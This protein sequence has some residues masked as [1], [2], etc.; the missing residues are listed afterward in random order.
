MWSVEQY[1]D[2]DSLVK[3]TQFWEV[4]ARDRVMQHKS[5]LDVQFYLHQLEE[6]TELVQSQGF[7]IIGLYGDY[8]YAEFGRETSPFMIWVLGKS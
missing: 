3:G 1:D 5:F 7:N 2:R 8:L 6:F 4:Y